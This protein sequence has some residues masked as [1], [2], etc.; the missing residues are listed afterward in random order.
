M[1]YTIDYLANYPEHLGACAAWGYGRWGVQKPHG[2]L[3]RA[4]K[5]YKNALNTD[6]IPMTLVAIDTQTNLPIAMGSLVEQD[7]KDWAEHT[8]WIA[9]IYTHYRRH[10]QGIARAMVARLEHEAKTLGFG[11]LHL[12]S[13]SAA[14][15][16]IELGYQEIDSKP[17]TQTAAGVKI[18]FRKA[19]T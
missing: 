17:T 2:S 1:S 14:S 11:H 15:L 4:I 5:H 3:E 10:G 16:Y 18:F 19:L 8:P 7:G 12:Y 13:G 6:K 9:S